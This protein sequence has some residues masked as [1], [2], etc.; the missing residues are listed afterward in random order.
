[1]IPSLAVD[2]RVRDEDLDDHRAY[3]V[4]EA[5]LIDTLRRSGVEKPAARGDTLV[6]AGTA[7][8]DFVVLLEG[9]VDVVH[10]RVGP[11]DTIVASIGPGQFGGSVALVTGEPVQ[12]SARAS[13]TSRLRSIPPLSSER[14]SSRSR[15]SASFGRPGRTAPSLVQ[16]PCRRDA[17]GGQWHRNAVPE[18]V[19]RTTSLLFGDRVAHDLRAARRTWHIA[20]VGADP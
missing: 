12:V 17:L 6:A 20:G 7:S 9:V 16:R 1:L 4:L 11:D 19:H 10:R 18:N 3:P 13:A 5:G 8:C 2:A 14:S 15:R